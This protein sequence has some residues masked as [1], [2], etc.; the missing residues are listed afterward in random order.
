MQKNFS[1]SLP[2]NKI[3]NLSIQKHFADEILACLKQRYK[4]L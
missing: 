4:K 1:H 2:N 3:V